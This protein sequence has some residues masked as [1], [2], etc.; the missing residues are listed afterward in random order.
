VAARPVGSGRNRQHNRI[1][2]NRQT[3]ARSCSARTLPRRPVPAPPFPPLP[4]IHLTPRTRPRLDLAFEGGI[5]RYGGGSALS[6]EQPRSPNARTHMAPSTQV[7]QGNSRAARG[8]QSTARQ[9]RAQAVHQIHGYINRHPHGSTEVLTI[10][11]LD[12]VYGQ[13]D[14]GKVRWCRVGGGRVES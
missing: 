6:P 8:A 9:S 11:S 12:V 10:A 5:S 7:P 13:G 4:P 1:R 3:C 14:G 2:T